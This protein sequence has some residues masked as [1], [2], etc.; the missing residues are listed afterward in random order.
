[1]SHLGL[2]R[3]SSLGLGFDEGRLESYST[4]LAS[5]RHWRSHNLN[6]AVLR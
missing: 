3:D 1:M 5:I 4:R 2:S 6:K